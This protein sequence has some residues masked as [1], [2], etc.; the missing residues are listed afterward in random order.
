MFA[1]QR[2]LAH[3]RWPLAVAAWA[4]LLWISVPYARELLV[5]TQSSQREA[6]AFVE[7]NFPPAAQ[8]FHADGGL[9]CRAD[10]VPF[11]SYMRET[12]E[13]QLNGP[14][15]E[16]NTD[17]LVGEFRK[18]PVA[19]VVETFLLQ[20][21]PKK[22]LA[23]LNEHYVSYR[24]NVAIPGRRV[25]GPANAVVDLDIIVTGN[26]RWFSA[27]PAQL[28]AQRLEPNAVVPLAVGKHTL[29]L[30]QDTP[31]AVLA[32][33]VVDPPGPKEAFHSIMQI[34]EIV[35]LRQRWP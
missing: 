18:R 27:G 25:R 8:G 16:H 35:G 11:R 21:F 20:P 22:V 26:Y 4:W 24:A 13:M 34:A 31:N 1:S 5:D 29:T 17:A 14:N 33:A 15:G 7:R 10:P 23:F 32:L 2:I 6:F 30:L 3:A 12:V 28:D 9:F 19:F